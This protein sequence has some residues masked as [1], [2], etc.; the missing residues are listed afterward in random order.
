MG[1]SS[2]VLPLPV[3]YD[4]KCP[5]A[6]LMK[7]KL[8]HKPVCPP[9]VTGCVVRLVTLAG[10]WLHLCQL[11][12]GWQQMGHGGVCFLVGA[13][14]QQSHSSMGETHVD[15]LTGQSAVVSQHFYSAT[16]KKK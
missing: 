9:V 16:G 13:S 2:L 3:K 4:Y 1:P 10:S 15:S 5:P 11:S 6:P 12:Q 14:L 7:E 8:L